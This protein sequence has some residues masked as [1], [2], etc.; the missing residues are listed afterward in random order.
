MKKSLS[1][2]QR[3][4]QLQAAQLRETELERLKELA[5]GL[6]YAE[7]RKNGAALFYLP[8]ASG[9]SAGRPV[10]AR[11]FEY[12]AWVAE[13]YEK[14]HGVKV[15]RDSLDTHVRRLSFVSCFSARSVPRTA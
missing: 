1:S 15:S 13:R 6:T 4:Q 3:K 7:Q 8:N 14:A 10:P 5:R 11:S 12:R 2:G 9:R